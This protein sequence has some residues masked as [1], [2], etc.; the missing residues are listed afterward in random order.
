MS[1]PRRGIWLVTRAGAHIVYFAVMYVALG[2]LF[3]LFFIAMFFQP[4]FHYHALAWNGRMS[5]VLEPN[6]RYWLNLPPR[7]K[8]T[9]EQEPDMNEVIDG[10]EPNYLWSEN[11]IWI[12]S[13]C[14][15]WERGDGYS[16]E[17]VSEAEAL[18]GIRLPERLRSFYRSW[19]RRDDLTRSRENL[20]LPDVRLI[21]PDAVTICVENQGTIFWSILRES[22]AD[23]DPPVYFGDVDWSTGD[24]TPSV[25]A[26]RLS[27]E[28][29]SDFLD[30]LVL[31]HTFA[32]G[33]LHGACAQSYTYGH[34]D[35]RREIA[36]S[37]KYAEKVIR[38]VLWGVVPDD[39]ERRWS[40]F[41]GDGVVI[42]CSLGVWIAANSDYQIDEVANF[43]QITWQERW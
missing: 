5:F 17:V 31:A 8:K 1:A 35:L 2:I 13:V 25:G 4:D 40:V 21:F 34:R 26:W 3:A 37:E 19:G 14:E 7:V 10:G 42:D 20:I 29:V 39:M 16:E 43:L 28:R 6:L 12:L 32:K 41:V 9:K 33:A 30:A 36:G 15:P 24:D 18:I 38:S 27:H 22:L 11:A 23:V